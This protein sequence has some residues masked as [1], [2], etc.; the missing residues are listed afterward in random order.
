MLEPLAPHVRAVAQH[1]D[2]FG[3]VKPTKRLINQTG[4]LLWEKALH[5]QAE[6]LMRRIL[7]IDKASFGVQHRKVA[8]RLNNLAQL[9]KVTNRLAEADPLM[10]RALTIDNTSFG[11]QYPNVAVDLDN[12]AAQPISSRPG[13][14]TAAAAR[15]AARL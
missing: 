7:A 6:P 5:S 8:I 1:A 9:L 4:L 3:I 15:G 2:A 10:H 13:A 12:L 14:V 11:A